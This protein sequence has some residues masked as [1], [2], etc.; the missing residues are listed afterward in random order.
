MNR[1]HQMITLMLIVGIVVVFISRYTKY[2]I[3]L[4]SCIVSCGS[5][6]NPMLRKVLLDWNGEVKQRYQREKLCLFNW[7]NLSHLILYF[8]FSVQYPEYRW[9]MFF[10]GLAW[11][12]SEFVFG[13]HNIMDP[14][15]NALGIL[16]G[17]IV[18][19]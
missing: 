9:T 15:W 1:L 8:V 5:G 18:R 12:I 11:E 17:M 2:V 3:E 16:M 4:N 6:C 13:H 10:I 7:W 14:F 19:P